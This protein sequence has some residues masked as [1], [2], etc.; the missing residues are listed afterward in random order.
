MDNSFHPSSFSIKFIHFRFYIFGRFFLTLSENKII[1]DFVGACSTRCISISRSW[2]SHWEKK[3]HLFIYQN[4][5]VFSLTMFMKF[6]VKMLKC[7]FKKTLCT[8]R[9]CSIRKNKPHDLC[10]DSI[11][12]HFLSFLDGLIC[13]KCFHSTTKHFLLKNEEKNQ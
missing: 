4:F 10:H 5:S 2:P 12:F 1:C 7:K 13:H 6:K 9:E 3:T 11:F 8:I